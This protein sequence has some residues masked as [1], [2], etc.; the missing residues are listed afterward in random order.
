MSRS[1][2]TELQQELPASKEVPPDPT[3]IASSETASGSK[4]P[5][6]EFTPRAILVLVGS[7]L[8]TFCSVGFTNAF[9]VFQT[10]YQEAFLSDKSSSDISWIGSFN[11]FCMFGCTFISGYLTDRYGPRLL[12]CFG[13]LV[14]VFALFM[15]SLSTEYYQIFLTQAF[16]FGVGIS[17]VLLPAMAT[18]SLYF[19]KS[20]SLAMGII[21][22]GSSLGGVIWPIALDRLF[23]EVSFGWTVRIAAFIMLPL[24]GLACLAIRRPAEFANRPK[25][26]ADFSCVKNPVM[27]FLAIGLFLIFLG[28]FS[29]FFYVTSYMISLGKDS[30]LAFYMVS[31]VNASSL[32]GRIL[33]G[34]IADRVGNYNVLFMV[35]V[36][37]GLVACCWTKATS[38]GGIVVF[39]LAY[40][41]ASGA[42]IS[43]QG[44]CAAQTVQ[45]EQF[46]VAMGVVMTFL[47]IA[48]LVGT[49][50]NG[51]ILIPYGYLGLSLFS[52]LVMLLGS[53]FILL[54]RLKIK[55]GLLVKA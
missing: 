15:L 5:S 9:G 49:P 8:V 34:L 17:F 28:L 40:G 29:P 7:F 33:P 10:Y 48:G 11:I 44:P 2:S 39:S 6:T 27:I 35:A 50:I 18:V 30:N 22:S 12:I 26:K 52:G 42:V 13:S 16:L 41:L 38:V 43:L 24:L 4:P 3:S 25:P 47:S 53:V 45:R 51:Q 37:S 19:A 32:F 55:T 54:A 46:G 23:N 31:V 20:R 1:T 14:M 21:V 36:F